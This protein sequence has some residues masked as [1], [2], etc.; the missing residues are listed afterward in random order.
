MYEHNAHQ[1]YNNGVLL[2]C[3][4]PNINR[5]REPSGFTTCVKCLG[6]YSKKTV[7]YHFKHCDGID[8]DL[9]GERSV[10]VLGRMAEARI[11]PEACDMLKDEIFAHM[12]EDDVVRLIRYDWLLVTYGNALCDSY[13]DV[14]QHVVISG[15][16]RLAG[17]LLYTLRTI[18][19]E[20]TDFASLYRPKF[21]ASV[22][23]AIRSIGKYDP[24][25]K[26][27]GSPSTS[28]AAV[29][30]VRAV[31]VMLAAEYIQKEDLESQTRTEN[32]NKLFNSG[33]SASV[34]K[35][36]YR[37]LT[38]N[39]RN[40]REKLPTTEDI[41]LLAKYI[42]KHRKASFEKLSEKFSYT[43]YLDLARMTMA[44]LIVFNR[45]RTGETQ[46]IL[47]SDYERREYLE[48]KW[49]AT[50][51]VEDKKFAKLYSRMQIRGKLNRTVPCLI[52]PDVDKAIKL[53]IRHRKNAKIDAKNE[54]LF[55]LPSTTGRIR[56]INA[57]NVLRKLSVLCGAKEPET[58]RGTKMRKHMASMCISME[59]SDAGVSEVATFMGHH[60]TVHYKYYRKM[61][62]VRD[63]VKVGK[64]LQAAQGDGEDDNDDEESDDEDVEENDPDGDYEE[65]SQENDKVGSVETSV[66][67]EHYE[68]DNGNDCGKAV[69][70]T[71]EGTRKFNFF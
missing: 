40:K 35:G 14:F 5:P 68:Q 4:R 29:T 63:V 43:T 52:K 45:R 71:I 9:N 30:L 49:L 48:E 18:D 70:E 32:F 38:T 1:Q 27:Y 53:L 66:V 16:L 69:T 33:V 67:N 62:I 65:W 26:S 50:L 28:K 21:Y 24:V 11:H 37:T 64:I 47:E 56:R 39:K 41:N 3:R 23:N 36:V 17:R 8:I 10:L 44:S 58:L 19:P 61:P 51:S 13:V 6:T 46:N 22:I 60:D 55:G 42:S 25:Q 31:G 15:K 34:S 12:T 57:C 54:F 59:L 20:V 7:R 2:T